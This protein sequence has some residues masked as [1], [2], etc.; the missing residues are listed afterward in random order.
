MKPALLALLLAGCTTIP[1][2]GIVLMP[3]DIAAIEAQYQQRF[4]ILMMEIMRLKAQ[5]TPLC[6]LP[7]YGPVNDYDCR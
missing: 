3:S 5:K 2:G 1:E 4:Q 6:Q 7:G